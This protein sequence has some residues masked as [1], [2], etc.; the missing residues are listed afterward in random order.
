MTV[1]GQGKAAPVAQVVASVVTIAI[2]AT[3]L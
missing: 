2:V 1:H 3:K